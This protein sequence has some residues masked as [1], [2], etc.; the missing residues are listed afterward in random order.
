MDIATLI[1]LVGAMVI[2]MAAIFV[3]G[4]PGGFLDPA[5]VLI[6]IG[7]SVFVVLSKFS[8][9]QFLGAFKVAIKAFKFKLPA[10]DALIEEILEVS[11]IARKDGF[12]IGRAHV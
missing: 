10:T 5:S 6:V 1:G 4:D 12:Q 8:L 11:R 3:G 9:Q 2:V 7:G